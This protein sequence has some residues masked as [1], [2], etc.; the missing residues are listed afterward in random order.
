MEDL[1]LG[2]DVNVWPKVIAA[3]ITEV[4]HSHSLRMRTHEKIRKYESSCL[5]LGAAMNVNP[6]Y[7]HQSI[8]SRRYN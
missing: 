3:K 4:A 1:G 6:G 2:E 8:I 7:V 5:C